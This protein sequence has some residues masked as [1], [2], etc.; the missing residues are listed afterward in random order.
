MGKGSKST[1]IKNLPRTWAEISKKRGLLGYL[2]I[3]LLHCPACVHTHTSQF[4]KDALMELG[5]ITL[6]TIVGV[7][8]ISP[9]GGHLASRPTI[10]TKDVAVMDCFLSAQS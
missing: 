2:N 8:T 10:I 9:V 1:M 4:Y 6:H 7:H 5:A 3:L